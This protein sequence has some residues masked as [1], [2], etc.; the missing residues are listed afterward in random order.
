MKILVDADALPRPL[1]DIL[2]RASQRL[3]IPITFV[4][5]RFLRL[6]ESDLLSVL[7][8]AEGPDEADDR[9]VELA[10][11]G[12]LIITAD[13][14]LADRVLTVGAHALDPRGL[15][16]TND[17]IKERLATRDLMSELRD[18]GVITGG[19]PSAFNPKD[20]QAFADGLNRVLTR[21]HKN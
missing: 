19:G 16:Y 9:I 10:E 8:A 1:R 4:T 11:A 2:L 13:I 17:N 7:V 20:A 6:P 14:P 15:L 12:D 3:S 18:T 21:L 5:N